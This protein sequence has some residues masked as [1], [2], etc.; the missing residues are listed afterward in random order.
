MLGY[1]ESHRKA[2]PTSDCKDQPSSLLFCVSPCKL[3]KA[4]LVKWSSHPCHL[5]PTQS[6]KDTK[7]ETLSSCSPGRR[8]YAGQIKPLKTNS[9]PEQQREIKITMCILLL[10]SGFRSLQFRASAA[11]SVHNKSFPI[12]FWKQMLWL[13]HNILWLH[14]DK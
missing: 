11:I 7:A 13:G 4:K 12:C 5:V 8:I 2:S 1:S 14:M 10:F 6:C 9:W 3:F